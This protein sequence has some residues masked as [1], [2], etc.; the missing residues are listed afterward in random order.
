MKTIGINDSPITQSAYWRANRALPPGD[1]SDPMRSF[2]QQWWN[3]YRCRVRGDRLEF[4]TEAD[5][6]LF[7]LRWA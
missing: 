6:L 1:P 5:Q 2:D 3:T 7:M 4:D